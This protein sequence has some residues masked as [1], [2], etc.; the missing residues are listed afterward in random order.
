M[1]AGVRAHLFHVQRALCSPLHTHLF[2]RCRV[3]TLLDHSR[4][5]TPYFEMRVM[6]ELEFGE[7]SGKKLGSCL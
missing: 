3:I 5:L 6:D 1:N 7:T 4:E 2:L